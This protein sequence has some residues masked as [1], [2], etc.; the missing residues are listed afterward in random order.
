MHVAS[1]HKASAANENIE[2]GGGG[3][4]V[5]RDEG[6]AHVHFHSGHV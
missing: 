3:M 6:S 4:R 1:S 5:V 2:A